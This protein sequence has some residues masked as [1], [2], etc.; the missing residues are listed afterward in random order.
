MCAIICQCFTNWRFLDQLLNPPAACNPNYR[1][2][3]CLT[4]TSGQP[5]YPN[6]GAKNKGGISV[7]SCRKRDAATHTALQ[8][9]NPRPTLPPLPNLPLHHYLPY[10]EALHSMG[11]LIVPDL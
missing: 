1:G 9:D 7:W 10:V 2:S 11:D 5:M 6:V 4:L 8:Q 3:R